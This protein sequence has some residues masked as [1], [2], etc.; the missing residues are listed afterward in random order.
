ML[1][2]HIKGN[3]HFQ[4]YKDGSLWYMTE[5][6]EFIFPVP[7]EDIGTATFSEKEKGLL[8]MRYIRKFLE[9]LEG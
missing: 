3:C 7:I 6:T 5:Y 9:L 4:Y 1:K 2:E 8:M